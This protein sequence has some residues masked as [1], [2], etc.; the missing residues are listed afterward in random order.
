MRP[1]ADCRVEGG[2]VEA[3]EL[4]RQLVRESATAK[5]TAKPS[6]TRHALAPS[7]YARPANLITPAAS[8]T[9]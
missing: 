9:L 8:S 3:V 4:S 1:V 2:S 6:R 7:T 5:L